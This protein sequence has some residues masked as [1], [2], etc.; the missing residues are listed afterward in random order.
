[1]RS[2]Q[3]SN[4]LHIASSIEAIDPILAY[5]LERNVVLLAGNP[6]RERHENKLDRVLGVLKSM[7]QEI[8][9]ALTD[10]DTAEEF[11]K[12]FMDG[13]PE[14]EE[15]ENLLGDKKVAGIKD[16][17]KG[18]KDSSDEDASSM[19]PSYNMS[20]KDQDDF[21]E[22][23][24]D[25]KSQ[26][27]GIMQ[28]RES[29]RDFLHEARIVI[30]LFDRA[31]KGKKDKKSLENI[32]KKL[33]VLIETGSKKVSPAKRPEAPKADLKS[34]AKQ[35][36]DRL[37]EA[38][39]SNEEFQIR[40]VLSDFFNQVGP[41]LEKKKAAATMILPDLIRVAHARIALRPVL[42]PIIRKIAGR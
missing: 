19:E 39:D 28:D 9:S 27:E 33:D 26:G 16:W 20:D 41:S 31:R 4:L 23:K 8:K 24:K 30:N 40:R 3:A 6:G 38:I 15:L 36:S 25:W 7:R 10:L 1:M 17:L 11:A 37:R 14:E 2:L 42:L 32:S 18:K 22:G 34:Q 35:L 29:D 12:F 5:E 21:V 13:L